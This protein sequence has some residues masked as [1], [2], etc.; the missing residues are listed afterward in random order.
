MNFSVLTKCL[1]LFKEMFHLKLNCSSQPC[2]D[3]TCESFCLIPDSPETVQ[4]DF[5]VISHK[6]THK[7]VKFADFK[8]LVQIFTVRYPPHQLQEIF[9]PQF[10]FLS[11]WVRYL[12]H[13]AG[14]IY[15]GCESEPLAQWNRNKNSE[16]EIK[17][18][19]GTG[20]GLSFPALWVCKK[21]ILIYQLMQ[22]I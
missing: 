10:V 7:S 18:E 14:H 16:T 19:Q 4:A 12:L 22:P 9:S 17:T 5:W 2:R 15:P 6:L 1:Y 8:S 3:D 11:S 20:F 21:F 13:H